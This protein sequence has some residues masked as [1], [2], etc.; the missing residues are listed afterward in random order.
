MTDLLDEEL[1]S[2]AESLPIAPPGAPASVQ[3]RYCAEVF[4][5]G[6]RFLNRGRHESKMHKEEKA[7]AKTSPKP[8]GKPG[9]KPKPKVAKPASKPA[10]RRTSA[11]DAIS[12]VLASA[13][14]MVAKVDQ[15][16][17]RAL[18]I[19]AP[20]TGSAIDE[21]VAG[22][23]VDRSVLQP[24]AKG[25]DKWERLGGVIAFPVL[26]AVISRRPQM[27]VP[28]E[29]YLRD[30]LTDVLVASVPAMQKRKA[31]E[32]K[33]VDALSALAQVDERYAQSEDPIGLLL[34]DIFGDP[35]GS[36]D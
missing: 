25:A 21:L 16:L 33:A 32:K 9:P 27:F 24:F 26:V 3:C 7:K 34:A 4:E 19:S 36:E 30:S 31:K 29:G 17:S 8:K 12:T 13:G 5:G 2:P 23:F 1:V 20:A 35:D 28:L 22:T 15:P 18:T 14:S 6:A 10:A 11:A